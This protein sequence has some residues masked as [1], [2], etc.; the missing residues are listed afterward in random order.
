M[1]QVHVNM[2]AA[3]VFGGTTAID[4]LADLLTGWHGLMPNKA[5]DLA[6]YAVNAAAALIPLG[7]A[8]AQRWTGAN[9]VSIPPSPTVNPPA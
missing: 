4:K 8:L 3:G 1:A 2:A 6:W 9:T 5:A 7:Y